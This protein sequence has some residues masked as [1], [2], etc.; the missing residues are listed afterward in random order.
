M[1]ILLKNIY[2][3]VRTIKSMKEEKLFFRKAKLSDIKELSKLRRDSFGKI[4]SEKYRKD[5]VDLLK[6]LNTPLDI[7]KKIKEYDMFCLLEKKK[8]IGTVSINKSEIKGVFVKYNY[9]R[10][11]IGTKLMNFIEDY[12]RKNKIK[13]VHLYSAEKAKGFYK[14]LGY[15]LIKKI[16]KPWQGVKSINFLMEKNLK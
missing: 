9:A 13:K 2:I 10:K 1:I 11:G 4:K 3:G 15:K 7:K 14:K 5:L 16:E 6:S 12:A 8:I